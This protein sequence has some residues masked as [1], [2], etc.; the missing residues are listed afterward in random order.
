[1]SEKSAYDVILGLKVVTVD[2]G[3]PLTYGKGRTMKLTAAAV[4]QITKALHDAGF[5]IVPKEPTEAMCE[6]GA[7]YYHDNYRPD[8]AK[9]DTSMVFIWQEMVTAAL[10]ID[11]SCEKEE[12]GNAG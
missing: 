6:A 10:H 3:W 5:L 1:M 4:G 2:P 12:V 7:K 8:H 9:E 11:K